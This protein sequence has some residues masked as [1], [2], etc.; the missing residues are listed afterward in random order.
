MVLGEQL[1]PVIEDTLVPAVEA[2]TDFI[3]NLDDKTQLWIATI[4]SAISFVSVLSSGL[5]L[6]GLSFGFLLG[7]VGLVI[8]AIAAFA[9]AYH[10]NFLGVRDITDEVI[11]YITDA[12]KKFVD[13]HAEQI[14]KIVDLFVDMWNV[15]GPI[16]ESFGNFL[17]KTLGD[18][19]QFVFDIILIVV[20]QILDMVEGLMTIIKG[21]FTLDMQM[22]LD[23][24]LIM[25]VGTFE[26]IVKIIETAIFFIGDLLSN[27][28]DL[29]RDIFGT[30]IQ[31]VFDPIIDAFLWVINKAIDVYNAIPGVDN[32]SH[33]GR[34]ETER[35]ETYETGNYGGDYHTGGVIPGIKGEEVMIKALAGEVVYNPSLGQT[36]STFDNSQSMNITNKI[37][38]YNHQLADRRA[39]R[40]LIRDVDRGLRKLQNRY[41]SGRS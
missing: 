8:L 6:L 19:V 11:S 37:N 41:P 36:A 35:G 39:Q 20:D 29:L 10:T 17:V 5:S 12:L 32:I 4:I 28:A 15:V 25:F 26:N 23:G 14:G 38:I 3:I 24:L 7:P 33:V 16:L 34:G 21:I 2:L 1:A 30:G 22:I 9:L 13:D 31:A 27:F 18:Q 40:N